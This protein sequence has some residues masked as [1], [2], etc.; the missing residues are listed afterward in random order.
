MGSINIFQDVINDPSFS[1][2][3]CK[4]LNFFMA[5]LEQINADSLC[6]KKFFA[7]ITPLIFNKAVSEHVPAQYEFYYY[8][9][10]AGIQKYALIALVQIIHICSHIYVFKLLL[11]CRIFRKIFNFGPCV[12]TSI[13]RSFRNYLY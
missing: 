6:G 13:F 4:P 11:I 8:I 3:K 7:K 2:R 1:I 10:I 9:I 12:W 5:N